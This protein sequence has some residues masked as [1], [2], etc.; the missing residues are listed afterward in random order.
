MYVCMYVC[1]YLQSEAGGEGGEK[2]WFVVPLTYA[3]IGCFLYVPWLG[4]L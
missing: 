2:H 3:F 4:N 1:M